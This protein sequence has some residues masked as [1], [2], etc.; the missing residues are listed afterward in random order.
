[1]PAV[2]V[3]DIEWPLAG[4]EVNKGFTASIKVRNEDD[5]PGGPAGN[6]Y[7]KCVLKKDGALQDTGFSSAFDPDA[8]P[9]ASVSLTALIESKHA[10]SCSLHL[11]S[12]DSAVANATDEESDIKVVAGG[13]TKRPGFGTVTLIEE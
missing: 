1:M 6:H 2:Y 13:P 7:V 9:L 11:S 10:L 12:D 3:L 4:T 8:E 5:I